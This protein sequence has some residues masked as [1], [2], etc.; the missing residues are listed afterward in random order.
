VLGHLLVVANRIAKSEGIDK[1]GYRIVINAG[2]HGCEY[3][4]ESCRVVSTRRRMQARAWTT[5][6]CTSLVAS[7]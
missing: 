4:A 2:P 3:A 7:S 1:T 5:S 6:T